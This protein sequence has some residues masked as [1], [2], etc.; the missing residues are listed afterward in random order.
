MVALNFHHLWVLSGLIL[1][2][3]VTRLVLL[4]ITLL[5]LMVATTFLH[6]GLLSWHRFPSVIILSLTLSIRSGV[7]HWLRFLIRLRALLLSL[8]TLLL[9][10]LLLLL[11]LLLVCGLAIIC[12]GQLLLVI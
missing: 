11:P 6:M 9:F 2:L 1:V 4:I 3:V 5:S 8:F 12:C 10:S 7:S